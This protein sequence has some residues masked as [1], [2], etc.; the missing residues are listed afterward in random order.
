MS[1]LFIYT[2]MRAHTWAPIYTYMTTTLRAGIKGHLQQ[3]RLSFLRGRPPIGY[4]K[5]YVRRVFHLS[6]SLI[7]FGGCPAHL[8]YLVD[9]SGRKTS[10]HTK[11]NTKNNV[12]KFFIII[13]IT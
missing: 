4:R 12:V 2:R 8:A 10:T 1:M 5:G 3:P 13:I 11:A 9:K 7:T 6:L